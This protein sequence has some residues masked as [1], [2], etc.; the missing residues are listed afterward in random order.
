[1]GGIPQRSISI[2]SYIVPGRPELASMFGETP[3]T[4]RIRRSIL[5]DDDFF[6]ASGRKAGQPERP[7]RLAAK[8]PGRHL[9]AGGH[10]AIIETVLPLSLE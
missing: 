2:G 4:N 7:R 5:F 1:M 3:Y 9:A 6:V 8:T 10:G